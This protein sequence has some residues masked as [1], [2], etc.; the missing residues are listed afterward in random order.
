MKKMLALDPDERISGSQ[1]LEHPWFKEAPL[2][3]ELQQLHL[4]SSAYAVARPRRKK[5]SGQA[6]QREP[7]H[8]AELRHGCSSTNCYI[9][10]TA[11]TNFL[12]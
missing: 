12:P 3:E 4:A 9:S 6:K 11:N 10:Y 7:I 2:E 5:S 8:E 1:A